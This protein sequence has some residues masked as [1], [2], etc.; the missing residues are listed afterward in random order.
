VAA[1]AP[2]GRLIARLGD[3]KLVTF[4]RSSAKPFQA[5]PLVLAGG[6]E[7]FDLD[8]SDLALICASHA[9]LPIHTQ[10]ARSILERGGFTPEDLQCG[11]HFPYDEAVTRELQRRG[12]EPSV[13]HNNCSGKHAGML[14]SCR[15]HGWPWADYLDP[16]HPLQRRI[17][18]EV[19]TVCGA[20]P[21]GIA[22]DGCSAP[23][24]ALELEQAAL[25][26]AAL[27]DPPERLGD[28]RVAALRRIAEAMT[29]HPEMVSGPGRFTTRLMEVTGGRILGKEGAEGFYC[30]AVRGPVALGV[31]LKVADG[32]ERARPAVVIEVLRQL[33]VL[34]GEE[35]D[36]L[37]PFYR[38]P[39]LNHRGVE[40]GRLMPD[41]E[42]ESS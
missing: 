17:R 37:Q 16:E 30:L 5:L 23:T 4:L 21:R 15:L 10:R 40:V 20:D 19:A 41:L 29:E 12:E 35:I 9:G 1:V 25:G 34:S 31:A 27:A 2:D 39:L 14:L 13:L 33:G 28:E 8:G 32:G 11:V 18:R 38:T 26:Y 24:F 3:P 7:K 42:L 36:E 22:I 6:V